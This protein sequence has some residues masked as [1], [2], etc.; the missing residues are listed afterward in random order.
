MNGLLSTVKDK[1]ILSEGNFP[2]IFSYCFCYHHIV[3]LPKS[4]GDMCNREWM[5]YCGSLNENGSPKL[6][7]LNAQLLVSGTL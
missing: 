4:E 7:Y 1:A 2:Y 5:C 3:G 6:T